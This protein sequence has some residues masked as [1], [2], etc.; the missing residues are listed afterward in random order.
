MKFKHELDWVRVLDDKIL[1]DIID[2]GDKVWKGLIIPDDD[3]KERGIRPR[4]AQIL[5]CG[6][7]ADA[8]GLRPGD[9][10]LIGSGDW[11]R[12]IME[13]TYDD[14]SKRGVWMTELDRV[15]GIFDE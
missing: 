3:F 12:K 8:E 11:T 1:I 9:I 7:E 13:A 2:R 6:P 14:G 5:A 10:V 4:K 15:M